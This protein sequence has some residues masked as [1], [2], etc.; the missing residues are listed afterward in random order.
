[1]KTQHLPEEITLQL[2]TEAWTPIEIMF[3]EH[4]VLIGADGQIRT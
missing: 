4:S 2:A 1:M 3:L